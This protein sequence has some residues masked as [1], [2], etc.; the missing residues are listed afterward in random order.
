MW[1][2]GVPV[3]D[4]DPRLVLWR[5]C[6]PESIPQ[7]DRLLVSQQIAIPYV[8][9]HADQLAGLSNVPGGWASGGKLIGT[10]SLWQI[11]FFFTKRETASCGE[12]SE[13]SMLQSV[14]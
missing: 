4:R 14:P 13:N 8:G 5:E 12:N 10:P 11:R 2:T 6:R 7:K 9:L 1:S 3:Q